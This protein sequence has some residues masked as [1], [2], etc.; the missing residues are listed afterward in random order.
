MG[1]QPGSLQSGLVAATAS[2]DTTAPTSTITSPAAGAVLQ[3]GTPV[4]ITGTATEAGGGRLAVVEVSTDSGATWHRATGLAS[5]SY[6]WTPTVSGPTVIKSRAVDDSV[7]LETPGAGVSVTVSTSNT[8]VAAYGF[9]EGTGS[10]V[11]DAS[12]KGNNGT[13]SGATWTAGGKYGGALSFDG[14]NDWVTVNDA[15]S[16]DLTGA[17]TLEAWV[18]PT[19]INGWETV[20]LKEASGDLAYALY[21]DN[22][23][24][25]SG[26]PRRPIVSVRQGGNT[27]WTAR[28]GAAGRQHLDPPGG[29]LRRLEPQDVRQRDAGQLVAPHRARST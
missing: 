4:T 16:L 25:D 29:H 26:G 3:V 6:T 17:M 1:V 10:T 23:G 14:V 12:G 22:N 24:N 21:A 15:N 9:N 19:A 11:A 20:I 13:I 5:W 7:N 18:Q 2:T 8:L 28:H 27:Y